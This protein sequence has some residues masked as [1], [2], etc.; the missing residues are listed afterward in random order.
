MSLTASQ[1]AHNQVG[2][3]VDGLASGRWV[4]C[5]ESGWDGERLIG[6]HGPYFVYS[7]VVIDDAEATMVVQELRAEARAK[8]PELKFGNFKGRPARRDVLRRLWGAGGALE[9]R[10][11]A[12]VFEKEYAAVAKVIDLLL[13]E[14]AYAANID[15]YAGN[16]ARELAIT[17]RQH[18]RRALGNQGYE[19]L[20][21]AFVTLASVRGRRNEQAAR[22]SFFACVE[23]AWASSTRR[24]VSDILLALRTTRP[25]AEALHK[26]EAPHPLLELLG[27]SVAQAARHWGAQLGPVSVLTDEQKALTDDG[28]DG[29]AEVVRKGW[30]ATPSS[31]QRRV[32]LKALVRG[33]STGH[34]SIQLADLF[35]GAVRV[36]YEHQAGT[37]ISDAGEELW[38]SVLPYIDGASARPTAEQ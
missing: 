38:P 20:M 25:Q 8:A 14:Q 10:C 35:A 27:S 32:D 19:R 9:G 30:G 28:L 1:S 31:R 5:D 4:A 12:F 18:G 13:E 29:I 34:P 33:T 21:S 22:E 7:A 23:E 3:T 26:G 17:L 11:W 37:A 36:S 16:R 2:P 24:N 15:L 6:C